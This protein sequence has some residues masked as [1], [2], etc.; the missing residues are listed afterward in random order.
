MHLDVTWCIK[1]T[2]FQASRKTGSLEAV[3][4]QRRTPYVDSIDMHALCSVCLSFSQA[5]FP[6][7]PNYS[8]GRQE[9]RLHEAM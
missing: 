5:L 1:V 7:P 2:F 8:N 4:L 9:C 3:C 6:F